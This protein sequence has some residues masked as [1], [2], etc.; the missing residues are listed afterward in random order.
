MRLR[1][2]LLLLSAIAL[3]LPSFAIAQS[4][5]SPQQ[6]GAIRGT[7]YDPNGRAVAGA[8]VTLL[9]STSAVEETQTDA[10]GKYQFDALPSASYQLAANSPGFIELST[11]IDLRS[12]EARTVDLHLT[13]SAVQQR[14][15]V[16]ASLGGELSPQVGSSVSVVT[17]DDIENRGAESASDALRDI[18]GVE[19]N[20][21]G[22]RGA[23]TSAFIR[24]G[25]SDYNLVMIDGIPLND[26]GGG[27]DLATLPAE[28]IDHI[29]VTRG[30][31]SALYGSNAVAGVID[32]VTTQGESA[33]HFDF[34]GEGGSHG[35][36]HIGTG[37]AG[38][39]HGFNW[40]YDLSRFQTRGP[41]ED[42]GFRNQTS[43]LSLGYSHSPRRQFNVHFFGDS[44]RSGTPG[45]YGSDPDGLYPGIAASAATQDRN[46]FAYQAN[47]IE[48][49]TPRFRQVTSVS[50]ETD[51]F[52]FYSGSGDSFTNNLRLV[53]NT[54][55][56]LRVSDS[57][58]FVA[59]FEY[60]HENFKD[61]YVAD[62]NS[63]PFNLPR[64][65]FAFF[66]ENRW[67]PASR[68]FLTTGLR[69]DNIQTDSLPPDAFGSRP[70]IPADSITQVDPR[71][72]LAYLARQSTGSVFG[73]TRVH[74]SFG[75]GIRPP[76]GFEL[77]FTNNP[78]LKPE[79]SISFDAGLE[80]R[81]FSDKAVLDVTYFYNRFKDQI[82]TLGGSLQ[83]LSTFTSAN[84]ANSRAYGL[85]NTLR[86][87]PIRSLELD[88]EYTWL[89]T[90]ILAVDGSTNV[91][92]PFAPGEP[93]VRRPHNSAG[94]NITWTH[95]RLM[96]NTNATIRGSVLDIEPNYGSYAC[97]LGL[98]CLFNN[99][100]YVDANAGFAYALPRGV[101]IFGHLN[102]LANQKYEEAFGFPDLRL[103]FMAGIRIRFPAEGGYRP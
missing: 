5:N 60:D 64:D 48:Q 52:A 63:N 24:G 74:T 76:D 98:Q 56:E 28:G 44:A 25:D 22:T 21:G 89:N 79:R 96:L 70:F 72:S 14:V 101:E 8:R 18:P 49:F 17:R 12:P 38:L 57:D 26:F 95:G 71:I 39:N 55:S 34:I 65:S 35:T 27:F 84:L 43:F 45:P 58:V 69:V 51:R 6:G 42:D 62:A 94:Y 81:L 61:T 73:A 93:L 10:H 4:S 87:R 85:E 92:S 83:N 88:G 102:N 20:Q 7:V 77:A 23:I 13:L 86:L 37:G 91:V 54:R 2:S 32:I 31:Q 47:Y 80:Q 11:K 82:V 40:A 19:I 46:M 16:S 36:S 1:F 90:A 50:A 66:A 67:S 29:E 30:P 33:P 9:S 3:F 103:N 78:G 100:G 97:T 53:V 68:W 99:K 41:V 75:T 15:V 59:G